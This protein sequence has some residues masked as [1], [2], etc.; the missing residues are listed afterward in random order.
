MDFVCSEMD[1]KMAQ[2]MTRTASL[3]LEKYDIASCF[4]IGHTIGLS[5]NCNSL[6]WIRDDVVKVRACVRARVGPL[7]RRVHV[8][9]R[10]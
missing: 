10:R 4:T 3:L 8:H 7:D 9:A 5:R 2:L 1:N 6:P